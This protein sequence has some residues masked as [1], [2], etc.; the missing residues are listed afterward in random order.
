MCIRDRNNRIENV[1]G[2][3]ASKNLTYLK[4]SNNRIEDIENLDYF[5]NMLRL[6]FLD[7]RRNKIVEKIDIEE[8]D[9]KL[10]ILYKKGLTFQ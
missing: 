9:K 3:M 1:K 6:E 8:F 4:I 7:I 5:K 2:L 10:K